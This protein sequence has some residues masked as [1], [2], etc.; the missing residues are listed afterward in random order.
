V[1]HFNQEEQIHYNNLKNLF[2]KKLL[3]F[4]QLLIF[5]C[6]VVNSQ[7]TIVKTNGAIILC[8]IQKENSNT[9][10]YSIKQGDQE[11]NL[12]IYK[13]DVN[14]IKYGNPKQI[15]SNDTIKYKKRAIQIN[16][17]GFSIGQSIPIGYFANDDVNA[18]GSGLAGNGLNINGIFT[19]FYR[20][21]LGLIIKGYYN[22]NEFKANKLTD[23]ISSLTNYSVSNNN[24]S[25][26]S[27]GLLVGYT[28]LHHFDNLSISGHLLL[29]F[30]NLT[31]PEI[32]FNV[33]SSTGSGWVKMSEINTNSLMYNFGIGLT[34]SLDEYWDI[35][36]NLD[37][38]QGSFKFG[39]YSLTTP[40]GSSQN[41]DRGSQNYGLINITAGLSIKIK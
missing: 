35:F 39:S 5:T 31:E 15:I 29:G 6:I 13:S 28:R 24:G 23:M 27:Y 34:Y 1:C 25:Y 17:I 8:K 4:L 37:Y 26:I 41:V 3:C 40:S 32:T 7:D 2:M 18:N 19:H 36:T 16:S 9:V 14:L 22:S 21:E 12:I 38:L 10:Y 11:Y 20:P 33:I 30:A